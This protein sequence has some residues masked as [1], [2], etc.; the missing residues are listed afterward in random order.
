[1]IGLDS[2]KLQFLAL[3]VVA[4]AAGLIIYISYLL[5]WP[6]L[7]VTVVQPYKVLTPTIKQ[8]TYM[9]YEVTYCVDKDIQ[10]IVKRELLNT[11]TGELWDVPDRINTLGQGCTTEVHRVLTPLRIDPGEYKMIAS[12]TFSVNSIKSVHKDYETEPFIITE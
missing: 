9:D 5:L 1:M 6:R 11:D 7:G 4:I 10:F 3:L 8:G 12:V 2:K